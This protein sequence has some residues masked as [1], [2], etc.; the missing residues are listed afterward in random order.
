[1][2]CIAFVSHTFTHRSTVT[3]VGVALVS[4]TC[5]PF[6]RRVCYQCTPGVLLVC[7]ARACAVS[8]DEQATTHAHTRQRDDAQT[9]GRTWKPQRKRTSYVRTFHGGMRHSSGTYR[10]MKRCVQIRRC[11]KKFQSGSKVVKSEQVP[12][13]SRTSAAQV[14][15]WDVQVQHRYSTGTVP[16][17][18]EFETGMYE[19]STRTGLVQYWYVLVEIEKKTM[20]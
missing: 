15:T 11:R 9:H 6:L 18:H 12:N 17:H 5:D 10:K 8:V 1:V 4:H 2:R 16:V 7:Y 14:R 20:M 19:Y 13:M 3:V